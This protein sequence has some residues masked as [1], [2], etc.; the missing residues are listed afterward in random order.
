MKKI[1]VDLVHEELL[2]NEPILSFSP[3]VDYSNWK[4]QIYEK[5]IELLGLDL[6]EENQCSLDL[7][8]E[9]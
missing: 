6:I 8:I 5:Y 7:E 4:K 3:D 2:K 9:E 1:D